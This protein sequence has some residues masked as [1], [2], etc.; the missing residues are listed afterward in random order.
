MDEKTGRRIAA[1]RIAR[2]MTQQQLADAALI[3]L[4]T[5]RKAEQGARP[6]TDRTLEAV[7]GALGVQADVL[8]GQQR[9]RTD[10]RVHA[11]I[12]AIRT[13]IDAYDLPDDGPVRPLPALHQAVEGMTRLRLASQYTRIAE[14]APPLLAELTRA[15][16]DRDGGRRRQAATLLT[17]ATRAADAVA[18]KAGYYDLSARMVELMR[19]AARQADDPLVEATAA[20]VRTETFFASRNLAPGLRALELALDQLPELTTVSA[21]AAA[22]ALHMR[23]AV[24]AARLTEAPACVAEHM[25]AARRLAAEVPEGVYAGTAFGPASVHAHEVSVAVELGDAARAVEVAAQP[26]GLDDLPAERR[27]HHHI[28]VARARLWLGLRDEAFD[29]LQEAR[30]TAPQH[31]REHPYVRDILVTLLRLHVSPPHALVAFAE[32]ARAI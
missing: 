24:V 27:S 4:S 31:V 14:T 9:P 5:L 25:A 22:G 8:T 6:I 23:A 10:S 17:A 12:P 1:T 7:A 3:S 29:S 26:V 19:W 32:W 21:R 11:A 30:R 28:E 2:R 16:Q 18:Y 15:I 13:A 20:Y